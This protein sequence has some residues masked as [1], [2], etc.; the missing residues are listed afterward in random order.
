M[1]VSN[2]IAFLW[3]CLEE[4]EIFGVSTN[5]LKGPMRKEGIEQGPMRKEGI[6]LLEVGLEPD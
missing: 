5:S 6:E 1:E 4:S 2:K 3:C